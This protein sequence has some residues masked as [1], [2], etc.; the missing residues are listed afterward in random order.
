ME[1]IEV[2]TKVRFRGHTWIVSSFD[3]HPTPTPDEPAGG[4]CLTLI[5]IDD[6]RHQLTLLERDWGRLR[7]VAS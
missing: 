4:P 7:P 5:D 3:P 6:R 2:G 1:A